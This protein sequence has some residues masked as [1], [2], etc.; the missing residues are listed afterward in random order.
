MVEFEKGLRPQMLGQQRWCNCLRPP[1][2]CF[3]A[4]RCPLK[5]GAGHV[6]PTRGPVVRL[7]H[8]RVEN[9]NCPLA[10]AQSEEPLFGESK[11]VVDEVC[12]PDLSAADGRRSTKT[13]VD[14]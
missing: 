14:R 11:A 7:I 8:Y 12:S 6:G 4:P 13:V 2:L 9:R 10:I 1:T 5:V 3:G